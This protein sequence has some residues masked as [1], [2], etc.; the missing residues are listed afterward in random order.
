ME[1]KELYKHQTKCN[2]TETVTTICVCLKEIGTRTRIMEWKIETY[3]DFIFYFYFY[4][5]YFLHPNTGCTNV[6]VKVVVAISWESESQ[7]SERL[8]DRVDNSCTNNLVRNTSLV[9]QQLCLH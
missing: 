8:G 2:H 3:C 9:Y 7:S 1:T 4:Y 5:L 6:D